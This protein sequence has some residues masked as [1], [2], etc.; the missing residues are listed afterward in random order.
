MGFCATAPLALEAAFSS[1]SRGVC[2]INPTIGRN[3]IHAFVWLQDSSSPMARGLAKFLKK[4]YLRHPLAIMA[5]W[6]SIRRFFPRRWSG[7][8]VDVIERAGT[9]IIVIAG[10]EDQLMTSKYPLIRRF[11]SRHA[12]YLMKYPYVVVDGADHAMSFANG[13]RQIIAIL[14]EHVRDN[15]APVSH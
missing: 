9:E 5:I 11:E 12:P 3:V 4:H 10:T 7:D 2:L 1:K 14:E 6:E 13:R 15:Y 8:L